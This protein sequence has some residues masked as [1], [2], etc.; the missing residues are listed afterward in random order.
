MKNVFKKITLLA[1]SIAILFGCT[2]DF[3]DM[4]KNPLA[5][6]TL[7][8]E[9]VFPYVTWKATNI[10]W[11]TYQLGDNLGANLWAQYLANT[12]TGF[13]TDRY[14][15]T[16]GFVNPGLWSPHFLDVVKNKKVVE[17]DIENYP[18]SVYTYQLLRIMTAYS[19]AK[20][21]DLFGD[22]PYFE[23]GTGVQKPKYDSQKDIYYDLFK[24]LTESAQ[25]LSS[26][27]Q[28]QKDFKSADFIYNGDI[29]KWVKFANS[30][31]LRLAIHISFVDPGKAKQEGEAALAAGVMGSNNESAT[32][33]TN[34]ADWNSLG[35]PLITISHW[36]EFRVSKTLVDLLEKSGAV[37]D[38]RLPLYIG[39]T[40]N[41]VTKGEGPEYKGMANGLP[42]DQF[43]AAGNTLNEISNVHGLMFLPDWNL[44]GID[45]S[46]VWIT[47]RYPV[48]LYS[49]VCFLK[50]E[51]ALLGWNGAGDA[52]TNYEEGIRSSFAYCREG[53]ATDVL[54]LTQ[55]ETY[56]TTGAVA[57]SA[58]ADYETKLKQIITQKY[59]ALFPNGNEAWTEYRRTGY[60]VFNAI[61][62]S[63][64]PDLKPG[65][66]IKKIRYTDSERRN[67]SENASDPSLNG[68]KGDGQNVRVWWDTNRS[69]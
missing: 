30:L 8:P 15:Y 60:P 10:N 50:A 47:K 33:Y 23:A 58:A 62:R 1:L 32:I 24:E 48:M 42:A 61:V 26:G 5:T 65:E 51:A 63:D 41:F 16:D 19:T 6:T 13:T 43:T 55:D 54:D 35:Y 17:A 12:S 49:E 37:A 14:M 9:L 27:L 3:E 64:D 56:I 7:S 39:K 20:V 57:W 34:N 36:N 45:Q 28:G 66:I 18:H 46:G 52:K 40:K 21:T 31:R 25:I 29:Q 59:I 22:I 53:I 68:G 4:N 11:E 2:D 69:K 38:P 67:N 44:N